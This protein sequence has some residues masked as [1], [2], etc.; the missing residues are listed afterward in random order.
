MAARASAR[1]A[2]V[3]V[4]VRR[5]PGVV[6]PAGRRRRAAGGHGPRAPALGHVA[7]HLGA[8]HLGGQQRPRARRG[9]AGVVAP[10]AQR[11][12]PALADLVGQ[13]A[14]PAP[15]ARVERDRGEHVRQRVGVVVVDAVLAHDRLRREGPHHRQ[16]HL[17][18]RP[19][20]DLVAAER[21]QGHVGRAARAPRRPRS[22]RGSPCRGTGA[23]RS[24]A[25]TPSGRAGRRS[26]ST[27]CRCRG[28][29]PRRCRR[30]ARIRRPGTSAPRSPSRCRS[31]T[32]S[33]GWPGR[34]GRRPTAPA[35]AGPRPTRPPARPRA[36]AEQARAESSCI[37]S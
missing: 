28:G 31:R 13:L 5:G 36:Q 27:G 22:R 21:R 26:R 35:R 37:P 18:H 14:Q 9:G 2:P 17:V 6:E 29:R 16:H 20:V 25:P 32:P 4:G 3:A 12:P 24:R 15:Q 7:A 8:R 1:G 10:A 33:P 30:P 11:H 19:L 23:A 34:G